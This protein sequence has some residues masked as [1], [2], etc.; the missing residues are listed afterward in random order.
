MLTR[1]GK[2]ISKDASTQTDGMPGVFIF[3]PLNVTVSPYMLEYNITQGSNN[4]SGE[5]YEDAYDDGDYEDAVNILNIKIDTDNKNIP[6]KSSGL[7]RQKKIV[8]ITC[9]AIMLSWAVIFVLSYIA[10]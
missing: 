9:L 7:S 3:N 8:I 10:K 1:K 6:E 4:G 5:Y 2:I